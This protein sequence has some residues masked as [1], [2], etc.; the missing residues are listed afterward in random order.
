MSISPFQNVIFNDLSEMSFIAGTQQFL[1]FDVVDTAGS[2]INLSSSTC[3][4][5][6]SPYGQPNYVALTKTG[7]L[8]VSPNNRFTVTLQSVDTRTLSGKY[9]HQPIIT[10]L[11]GNEF[12]PSQG[13]ITVIPRIA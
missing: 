1:I 9:A 8:A 3:T 13:V 2:P 12:R 5:V 6:M 7:V 10:D 11:T 4:W